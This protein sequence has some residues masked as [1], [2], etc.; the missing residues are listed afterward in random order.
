MTAVRVHRGDLAWA[1][2]A[3]LPHAG[4]DMTLPVLAAVRI[5]AAPDGTVYCAATDRYTVASAWIPTTL[6]P[7]GASGPLTALLT[8]SDARELARR[9]AG[10][11]DQGA[12]LKFYGDELA[13]DYQVRYAAAVGEDLAGR[14]PDWRQILGSVLRA[15]P[16]LPAATQG[17]NP[18]YL[19]RFAAGRRRGNSARTLMFM[20]VDVGEANIA[21]SVIGE[22]FAGAIMGAP[23]RTAPAADQGSPAGY[24]ADWLARIT[25]AAAA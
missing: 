9:M 2:K 25:P 8:V 19:G 18:E 4:R 21:C 1:L 10:D 20:P 12:D 24:R 3:V 13:A 22:Q 11:S 7:A 16:A 5:E 6:P 17:L 15:R 23:F 14:Y